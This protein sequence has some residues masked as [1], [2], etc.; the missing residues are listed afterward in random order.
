MYFSRYA[1]RRGA[2]SAKRKKEGL[3][4]LLSPHHLRVFEEHTDHIRNI[5]ETAI[6]G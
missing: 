3:L 2:K 4:A 6:E 1:N 5:G